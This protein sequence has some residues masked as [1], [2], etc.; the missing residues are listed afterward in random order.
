M[1]GLDTLA[2]TFQFAGA[3]GLR[4]DERPL[5][6]SAQMMALCKA[7]NIGVEAFETGFQLQRQIQ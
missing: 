7:I 1:L 5:E 2:R 4:T 6:E 3:L